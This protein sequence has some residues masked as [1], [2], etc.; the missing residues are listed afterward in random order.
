MAISL[1]SAS[2]TSNQRQLENLRAKHLEECRY[3][4]KRLKGGSYTLSWDGVLPLY[5]AQRKSYKNKKL[6][7]TVEA[8]IEYGKFIYLRK[9]YVTKQ[10]K[11]GGKDMSIL[12]TWTLDQL[13]ELEDKLKRIFL[14]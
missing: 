5:K 6:E 3:L 14:V 9:P 4:L 2:L 7:I 13:E 11:V 8:T 1:S 10:I 12:R